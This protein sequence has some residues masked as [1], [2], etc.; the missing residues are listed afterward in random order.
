MASIR[1]PVAQVAGGAT[2]V[3]LLVASPLNEIVVA[4]CWQSISMVFVLITEVSW[5]SSY[6]VCHKGA[7]SVVLVSACNRQYVGFCWVWFLNGV[8]E[9]HIKE[10]LGCVPHSRGSQIARLRIMVV[11]FVYIPEL[12]R[13]PLFLPFLV[14]SH[15][16]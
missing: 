6:I 3:H 14:F 11:L 2:S 13:G 1:E 15:I 4:T 16:P 12:H 7:Q 9:N 5:D 8:I 10:R